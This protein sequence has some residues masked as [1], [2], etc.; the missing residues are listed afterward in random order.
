M[1]CWLSL[2]FNPS[3]TTYVKHFISTSAQYSDDNYINNYFQQDM[4]ILQVQ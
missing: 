2:I 4:E 3:S 1:C